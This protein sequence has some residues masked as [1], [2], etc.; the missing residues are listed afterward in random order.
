VALYYVFLKNIT[1][2]DDPPVRSFTVPILDCS[3]VFRLLQIN[4]PQA[5]DQKCKKEI[6]VHVVS[7]RDV[8]FTKVVT[9][10]FCY[11][12]KGLSNIQ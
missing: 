7:G 11:S 3:Y 6:T 1:K 12:Q 4:H 8:D 5:V 10:V 2:E 9:Y